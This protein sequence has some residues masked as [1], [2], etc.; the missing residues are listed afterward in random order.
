MN[1]TLKKKTFTSIRWVTVSM[2][3]K[4]AIYFLQ[5][6]FLARL[7][8][9]IDFGLIA[10]LL[11]IV[12]FSQI[13]IDFGVSS[14]ILHY[15]KISDEQLS[16]LFWVNIIFGIFLALFIWIF[17]PSVADY[18]SE[19]KL[20]AL[21]NLSAITLIISSAGQLLRTTAEKNLNFIVLSKIEIVS[22][23]VGFIC[24]IGL[25]FLGYGVYSLVLGIMLTSIM[26]TSFLW[27]LCSEGWRPIFKI[28]FSSIQ[29]FFKFG[30]Y[31]T[32]N[33]LINMI[34]YQAD[35]FIGGKMLGAEAIGQYNLSKE[36]SIGISRVINPI[37]TRV[38]TPMM[39]S[40]Q[41]DALKI[42][43][44]YLKTL[45]MTSS[46]NFPVYIGCFVFSAEI[47]QIFFGDQWISSIPILQILSIWGLLRST[48]N[49]VG[50]LLIAKGRA[51]LSFKWNLSI[52]IIY[53]IIVFFGCNF[54]LLGLAIS[55]LLIMM[56]TF[57]PAWYFLIRPL[58]G[59]NIKEYLH[60]FSIPLLASLVSVS[61][62]YILSL[63]VN[64]I[65]FKLI[66]GAACSSIIY[67]II[68]YFLNK[69]WISEI[70]TL[71]SGR[72]NSL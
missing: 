48:S 7:L 31:I 69:L 28:N 8:N 25:A 32:L 64:E 29:H 47:V 59:A 53:P 1:T 5:L 71:L 18:Y 35:I 33:N 3:I 57:V 52:S 60:Q 44:I 34:N 13:F 37:V 45:R 72:N 26:L 11:A 22:A 24:T 61:L 63:G 16:S 42:K 27:I 30:I 23:C 55:A 51:D 68:S 20:E 38:G 54:G 70:Y 58:C 62:G 66:I 36:F 4:G 10:I 21:L 41:E 43:N 15:Q 6:A 40:I 19:P 14:A 50:G 12:S 67:L 2:A 56:I 65:I 46:V 39:S 49:P 17:S 9:P